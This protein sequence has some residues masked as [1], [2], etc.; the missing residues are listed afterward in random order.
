MCGDSK[1]NTSIKSAGYFHLYP[2][3]F[4]NSKILKNFVYWNTSDLVS[5]SSLTELNSTTYEL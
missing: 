5:A 1:K 2:S 4:V 3:F